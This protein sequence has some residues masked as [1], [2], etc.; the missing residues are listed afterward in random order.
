MV[1]SYNTITKAER[2][3][4]LVILSFISCTSKQTK[5]DIDIEF[6]P[7]TLNIGYTYWWDQSGPFIGNCGEELS[8]V[9][10]GTLTSLKEP[11]D[12]P[13]PL[14]VSQEGIIEIDKVY[15]IK[16]LGSKTYLGQKFVS[17]DC[18]YESKIVTGD[19]VLVFC[20]DYEGA[21]TLPGKNSI[22]KINEDNLIVSSI[23]A[24]I[25]SDQDP[26]VIKKDWAVW[27]K[28]GLEKDLLQL[29]NCKEE[30][31]SAIH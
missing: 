12:D 31:D 16:N 27:R 26:T 15:K 19:R 20:Y 1:L 10:E 13:G 23:R 11:T 17:A 5:S 28:Y 4:I 2:A 8:L 30:E 7:D 24:Y 25:D 18:F 21:Y 9:F 6:V 14:Y 29:L 3:L 22:L